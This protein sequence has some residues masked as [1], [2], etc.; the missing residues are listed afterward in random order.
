MEETYRRVIRTLDHLGVKWS[1][2][3]AHAINT[4]TR[5]RATEDID[6]IVDAKRM[7]Q[8]L[9]ALEEE[10]GELHTVDVGAAI[11]VTELS[12][13]LIRSDNHPL[14]WEALQQGRVRQGVRIPPAEILIALKFLA[15]VSPWR[16]PAER[17]QDAAD[18]IGVYQ[19]AGSELDIDAVLGHASRIYPGA[20][21]ELAKVFERIDRG[22]DVSL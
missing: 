3:G 20:E 7:K 17:K 21:K 19:A 12:V 4:Y 16:R 13:D 8:V 1:L 15:A 11:R 9:A 2:V 18:L 5:P 6:L 10:F 14:F 22:E